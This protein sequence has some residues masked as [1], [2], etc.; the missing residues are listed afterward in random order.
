MNPFPF[1]TAGAFRRGLPSLALVGLALALP[2]AVAAPAEEQDFP[3]LQAETKKV[4]KDRVTPFFKTYCTDCHGI[5]RMEGGINFAPAL[6]AP[7]APSSVK[8]WKQALAN[9]K[10]HDMPPDYAKKQPTEA[11]LQ[12]KRVRS[13]R[14]AE[15][16]TL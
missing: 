9:V 15:D 14:R 3:A 8:K 13:R 10:A 5:Y 6:Q 12:M 2:T 11:E 7:G 4:F 16:P 1:N